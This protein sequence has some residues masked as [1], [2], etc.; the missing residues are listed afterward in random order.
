MSRRHPALA[1]VALAAACV[2]LP[3]HAEFNANI[4][5]DNTYQDRGRGLSQGGR[6]EVNAIGR[7]LGA[8]GA[9]IAGKAS[10]LA[11]RDSSVGMDDLWVQVGNNGGDVKLGRFE[12]ADVFPL[13]RDTVVDRAG[14]AFAYRTNL[15]RGRFTGGTFHGAGTV[16]FGGGLALELGLVESKGATYAGSANNN[17]LGIPAKGVRPVLRYEANG[18]TVRVGAEIGK[19]GT[20]QDDFKGFGATVG[21]DLGGGTKVNV[22]LAS[23]KVDGASDRST[24]VGAGAY[25]GAAHVA[26]EFAKNGDEKITTAYA[27][28]SMPLM[29]I[30]GAS[31]TPALS[32]SKASNSAGPDKANSLRVRLNY[33]F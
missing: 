25:L 31:I 11:K 33:A 21:A 17:N 5:F 18:M 8:D 27:S 13:G 29:G 20:A 3:A 16:K 28:Y 15:L 24:T 9:F 2:A 12:A 6:V 22:N 14:S 4:E 23:A 19:V 7:G 10:I 1:A 32:T 30:K 26:L